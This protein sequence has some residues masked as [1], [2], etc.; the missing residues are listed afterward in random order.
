MSLSIF[1]VILLLCPDDDSLV[2]LFYL[3]VFEKY[4]DTCSK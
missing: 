3:S 4:F 1:A 2:F